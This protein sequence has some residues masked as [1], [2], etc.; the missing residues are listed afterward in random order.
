MKKN[1]F[2]YNLLNSN[3]ETSSKRFI[4]ICSMFIFFF[5]ILYSVLLT[6]TIDDNIIYSLV[7]LILGSS[8]MTLVQNK[9]TTNI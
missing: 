1:N 9:N 8:A 4:S 6:K 2:F 5:I 7:S 3:T